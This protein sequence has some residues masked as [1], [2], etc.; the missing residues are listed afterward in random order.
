MRWAVSRSRPPLP[1]GRASGLVRWFE[2][3]GRDLI[4]IL[5][6]RP[7]VGWALPT[8]LA[9]GGAHPTTGTFALS[10]ADAIE[11][12][13]MKGFD[14]SKAGARGVALAVQR[15]PRRAQGRQPRI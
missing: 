10:S 5:E 4:G 3:S 9:V 2:V 6:A 13:K 8:V 11:R 1:N 12:I 7:L 14:L 15:C